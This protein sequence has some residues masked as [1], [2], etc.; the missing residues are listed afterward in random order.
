MCVGSMDEL[1]QL[2][3]VRVKDLHRE[4]CGASIRFLVFNTP[5]QFSWND[6]KL[7]LN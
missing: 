5:K 6:K 1:E 3:G 4:R 7:T 2:S